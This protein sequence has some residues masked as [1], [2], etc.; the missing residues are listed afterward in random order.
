MPIIIKLC[1]I[2]LIISPELSFAAEENNQ[3]NTSIKRDES[4]LV[5]TANDPSTKNM[6]ENQKR[7]FIREHNVNNPDSFRNQIIK[8]LEAIDKDKSK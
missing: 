6:T 3:K 8:C 7:N 5:E 2:F 4:L 1:L